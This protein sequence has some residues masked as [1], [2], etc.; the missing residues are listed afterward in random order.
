LL[1]KHIYMSNE[2][3]LKLLLF[4]GTRHTGYH[5][6][7]QALEAGHEVTAIIRNPGA[8]DFK[9]SKLKVVKGDALQLN[10]FENEVAGKD[11]IISSLG[12]TNF[13]EPMVACSQG[14]QNM[15]KAMQQ[16][17]VKRIMCVSAAALDTNPKM[18]LPVILVSKVL[19][20][21]FRNSY[22]D[23]EKMETAL[24]S[25]TVN[26]TIVRAPRLTDKPLTGKCR[27]AIGDHLSW[28]GSISRADVAHWMLAHVQ[29]INTY[30][31]TVEV[32][33]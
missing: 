24:K 18:G 20:R 30:K 14:A 7:Q 19:Q 31:K 12:I 9:H 11:A 33:Y 21:I 28:P 8:F 16:T 5:F 25:S 32:S 15:L 1:I 17:G 23:L 26:W 27:S 6:M 29:D 10:T 3:K 22:S 13:K 2:P 4:G